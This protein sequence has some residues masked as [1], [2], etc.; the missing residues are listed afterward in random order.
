VQFVV[1][2][3]LKT[4]VKVNVLC[5]ESIIPSS[6]VFVVKLAKRGAGL[7]ITISSKLHSELVHTF[8][9]YQIY[10]YFYFICMMHIFV[11]F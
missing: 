5:A 9:S 7:G 4:K 2:A 10:F 8:L 1:I 11:N 3:V 6:G